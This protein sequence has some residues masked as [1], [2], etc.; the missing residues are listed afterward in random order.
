MVSVEDIKNRISEK[1]TPYHLEVIDQSDGCGAK[2][3]LIVV[4]DAFNGK[5]V[6]ECHR[7]VQES[8]ADIMSQIHA[9]SIKAYTKSKWEMEQ[10]S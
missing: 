8:I 3:L 2:F 6:L 9:V 5:K 7:L 4:S 1:L 10:K